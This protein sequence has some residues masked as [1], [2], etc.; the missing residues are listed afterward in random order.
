MLSI[1][2]SNMNHHHRDS[3]TV[4]GIDGAEDE[5]RL[6]PKDVPTSCLLVCLLVLDNTDKPFS[7]L[8]TTIFTFILP[9]YYTLT[10][11]GIP[12]VRKPT[13]SIT[14]HTFIL[15]KPDSFSHE[16]KVAFHFTGWLIGI[17]IMAQHKLYKPK[18]IKTI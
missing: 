2:T 12:T 10:L 14:G 13:S 3:P 6:S 7:F 17:L 9:L 15:P 4:M 11:A 18:Y 16:N 1:V 8:Y 5:L